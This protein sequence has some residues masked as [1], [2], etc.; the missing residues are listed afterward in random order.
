MFLFSTLSLEVGKK[1]FQLF[2]RHGRNAPRQ[3]VNT[4]VVV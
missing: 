4:R 3:N 2:L 1:L